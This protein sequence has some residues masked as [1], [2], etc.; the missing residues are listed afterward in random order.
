MAQ[1]DEPQA[2]NAESATPSAP[3]ARWIVALAFAIALAGL[4][5]GYLEYSVPGKWFKSA[6]SRTYDSAKFDVTSGTG[7]TDGNALIATP[8]DGSGAVIVSLS[9]DFRSTEYP[10]IAWDVS[11][12]PDGT[13]ARLLWRSQLKPGRT[14]SIDVPVAGGRLLPVV[15]SSNAN[16]LGHI[17]GI[18]LALKLPPGSGPVRI[19]SVTAEPLSAG[20]VLASRW[21]EWTTFE[22]WVGGSIN[23]QIGGADVQ[24]LPPALLLAAALALTFAVTIALAIWRP[25]NAAP[26]LPAA[27]GVLFVASWWLLDARWEWNLVRQAGAT[28]AQYGGKDLNGKHL[29]AEDAVLYAFI[30]KARAKLPAAPLRVFVASDEPYFGGRA[31]Y[32][33][34]PHNV[35]FNPNVNALPPVSALHPGDYVVVF[36]RRGLDYDR[37]QRQLRWDGGRPIAADAIFAEDTGAVFRIP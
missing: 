18:A 26:A 2:P 31:A 5:A 22:P 32:Y 28:A 17:V 1:P 33:L 37:A 8:A 7:T 12:L 20:G 24:E 23:S 13:D 4:V 25:A 3:R 36:Q 15:A 6:R 19:R 14:F 11:G 9:V 27:L 30:E 34:Y 10:G 21:R 29:A 16:W 35:Y